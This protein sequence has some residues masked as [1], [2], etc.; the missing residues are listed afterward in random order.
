MLIDT[1]IG[2]SE[3]PTPPPSPLPSTPP[4]FL[5]ATG[6]ESEA[7]SVCVSKPGSAVFWR[8]NRSVVGTPFLPPP[9][10]PSNQ[11]NMSRLSSPSTPSAL[12][13]MLQ[14]SA[15]LNAL[16]YNLSQA[17]PGSQLAATSYFW[18]EAKLQT[19][20]RLVAA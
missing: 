19:A 15:S 11:A 20:C 16:S 7:G 18:P 12:Q 3:D 9:C 1:D 5:E 13:R 4:Q 2:D 14:A 17:N 6:G 10:R 8:T